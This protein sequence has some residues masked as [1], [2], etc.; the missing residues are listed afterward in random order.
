MK[1]V[2]PIVP[3]YDDKDNL[4]LD[5]I[6]RYIDYIKGYYHSCQFMT[7]AGTSQFN[8][9]DDNEVRE[10]NDFI[11]K[12]T[13]NP[14]IGLKP[15]SI[16]NIKLEIDYYNTKQ[17]NLLLLFPDRYY[18]DDYIIDY[19]KECASYSKNPIYIHG[20]WLRKGFG[21]GNWDY[22]GEVLNQLSLIP[23]IK[24]IKEETSTIEKSFNYINEI[25]NEFDIIVAGGSMK[26]HWFLSC[27]NKV[28]FLSGIGSIFPHIEK[29]YV[30]EYNLGNLHKCKNI[31]EE[32]ETPLFNIFM[33]IGWHISLKYS[34]QKMGFIKNNRQPSFELS[35]ESKKEIDEILS[36]IKNKI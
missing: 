8:L 25:K 30:D 34:L 5:S 24:G 36:L 23:K 32:F 14:I 11:I 16:N 22:T 7:T 17:C 6:L 12:E 21:G 9:L 4:D 35:E 13:D 27:S 28:S 10:L 3:S 19:F 2:F 18:S 15:L 26:R 29:K 33:K 1:S 31:I 20:M